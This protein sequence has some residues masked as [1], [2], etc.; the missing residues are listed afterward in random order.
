VSAHGHIPFAQAG[1][2]PVRSSNR[3]QPLVDGEPAFR[4]ICEAIDSAQHSVWGTVAFMHPEFRMPDGRGDL[5]AVL[6]RAAER[7]LDVR[8]IYWRTDAIPGV[9][10]ESV[11]VGN[12]AHRAMLGERG[13]KLRARWDRAQDLFCQHQKS[14]LIDAGREREIA[15]VG[16]M[17][18][19]PASVVAP[20]HAGRDHGH[21]HDLYL[22]LAGPCATDVHHNFVQRW[23][24]ASERG[25][26]DGCW[27]NA[28]HARDLPFPTRASSAA[29]D[30]LAQVQRTVRAGLY[31]DG[32]ATPG[33][34]AFA[35]EQGDLSIYEQYGKAI[36][37]ARSYVYL[38]NQALAQPET[39]EA[40][41]DALGRGVDVT[42]L[43]PADA[44]PFFKQRRKQPEAQAFMERLGAL[45]EHDRFA[46]AGIAAPDPAGTLRD[47]Y[48][49]A[50]AALIDDTWATIGSCNVTPR[51][52]FGHTEMNVSFWSPD[53]VRGLR[54]ELLHEHLGVDTA[55]LD[56]RAAFACYRQIAQDNAAR[57]ARG[58]LLHG[59]A[60][61]IDPRT[62][63]E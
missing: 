8:V 17:N 24:E 11:F 48:V 13:G 33:G 59:L 4:R 10:L 2:Y 14:W 49:H 46:L 30:V 52:F 54:V 58:E 36:A 15:F 42:V 61:A 26:D 20:G 41:H 21:M 57:K 60:F 29:G 19:N 16:G 6:A 39:V 22:E 12:A 50:K 25:A 38:E 18:L 47:I 35:I 43:V 32:T 28:T 3:V 9:D 62:Y 53:V 56:P 37:A 31:E 40:L 63:G 27:P 1:S 23:N 7:G 44:Q 5:F 34:T 45:G 55:G 51:S